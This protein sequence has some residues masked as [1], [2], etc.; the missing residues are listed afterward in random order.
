MYNQKIHLDLIWLNAL[1][2]WKCTK[3]DACI[4][5]GTCL[6]PVS[7]MIN[8]LMKICYWFEQT[9]AFEIQ[10]FL[11]MCNINWNSKEKILHCKVN[12]LKN[13]FSLLLGKL[14]F[15]FLFWKIHFGWMDGGGVS[16][17]LSSDIMYGNLQFLY[18]HSWNDK[19]I[20]LF[21]KLLQINKQKLPLWVDLRKS[22]KHHH[23]HHHQCRN[24]NKNEDTRLN[25]LIIYVC[26]RAS[27]EIHSMLPC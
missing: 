26:G 9:K 18:Y 19:V 20:F 27:D 13:Q 21:Y 2:T 17:Q 16:F 25:I 14:A 7:F 1:N 3:G 6:K 8:N 10:A 12:I 11:H 15:S 4:I 24:Q 5:V 22:R 23:H